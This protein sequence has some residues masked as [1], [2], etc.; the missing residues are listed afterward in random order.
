MNEIK[1]LE[2]KIYLFE[3]LLLRSKNY[4]EIER[5]RNELM[6]MRIELQ[7]MKYKNT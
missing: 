7:K 4:Y 2:S 3:D 1:R 5:I 6:K